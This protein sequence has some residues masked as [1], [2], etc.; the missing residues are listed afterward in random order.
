M[1]I[2]LAGVTVIIVIIYRS[3]SHTLWWKTLAATVLITICFK[4]YFLNTK[5][6]MHALTHAVNC[7]RF[8]AGGDKV[9][10]NGSTILVTPDSVQCITCT[11][12][13]PEIISLTLE[14]QPH[15]AV[16][17]ER[18]VY[19]NGMVFLCF[20]VSESAT[21]KI[22]GLNGTSLNHDHNLLFDVSIRDSKGTIANTIRASRVLHI[23][24]C[25]FSVTRQMILVYI[26]ST[27]YFHLRI[28]HQILHWHIIMYSALTELK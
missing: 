18:K 23:H 12:R 3:V 10:Q 28:S 14:F 27:D 11:N 1:G 4:A 5:K 21:L 19:S 9:L 20:A 17:H 22:L 8:T 26:S 15:K 13:T 16:T 25:D 6:V 7:S 2:E 24:F